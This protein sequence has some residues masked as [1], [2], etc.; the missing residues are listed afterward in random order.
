LLVWLFSDLGLVLFD[1]SEPPAKELAASVLQEAVAGNDGLVRAFLQ[2]CAQVAAGGYPLQVE[3]S[4][5]STHLFLVDGG[6]RRALRREREGGFR[7]G[8]R[9]LSPAEL[10]RIAA[11]EPERLSPDVVLRP[12][13]AASAIPTAAVVA[14]PGEVAYYAQLGQVFAYLG[15]PMPAVWPRPPLT[16]IEPPVARYLQ[17]LGLCACDLTRSDTLAAARERLLAARGGAKLG[18]SFGALTATV[19]AA[20]ERLR[21]ELEAIDRGL[22]QLSTANLDRVLAQVSWL[23]RRARQELERSQ[24]VLLGQL[25][26]VGAAAWPR[27]KPQERTLNVLPYVLRH[28]RAW[29]RELAAEPLDGRHQYMVFL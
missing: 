19:R 27:G 7:A 2:G 23:E 29:L 14:G 10:H 4:P 6:Q 8:E 9:R 1:P 26:R 15:V 5:D 24:G 12:A 28:G 22:G 3:K 17:K 21:P 11:S 18:D 13:L 20:Y 16:L 25:D